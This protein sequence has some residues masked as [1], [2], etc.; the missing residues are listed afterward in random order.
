MCHLFSDGRVFC[1]ARFLPESIEINLHSAV[2]RDDVIT[3]EL[4]ANSQRAFHTEDWDLALLA[5]ARDSSDSA[6][7][8]PLESLNLPVLIVWG[9]DDGWIAPQTAHDLQARIPGAELVLLP[10]VGHL[11]MVEAPDALHRVLIDFWRGS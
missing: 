11:P 5:L 9:E 2:E 7:D 1:C 10:G 4:I 8:V 6:L 3:P